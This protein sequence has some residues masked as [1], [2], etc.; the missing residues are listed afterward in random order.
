MLQPEKILP[1]G[2][3]SAAP[4]LKLENWAWA[5]SRTLIA[6]AIMASCSDIRASRKFQHCLQQVRIFLYSISSTTKLYMGIVIL[7]LSDEDS[8]RIS[9]RTTCTMHKLRSFETQ[10]ASPSG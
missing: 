1:E 3:C 9:T 7:R 8:R 5:F 10:T 4:T 2:V 6:A